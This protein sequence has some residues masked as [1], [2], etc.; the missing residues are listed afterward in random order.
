MPMKRVLLLATTTGYQTR[1]FGE[2][3]DA[4]RRRA[5]L[6]DRS[7]RSARRSVAGRRDRRALSRGDRASVDTVV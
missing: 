3:A 7:L 4:A 6:R 2:A 5:G 1:M